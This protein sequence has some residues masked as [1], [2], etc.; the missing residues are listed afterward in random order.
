MS[1]QINYELTLVFQGPVITQ[2][3]GT[4]Q[5]G[6]DAAM[7]YN[8]GLPALGGSLIK[9]NIRHTLN[10]F[11]KLLPE[12]LS[13][14][15]KQWF[16]EETSDEKY[17]PQRTQVDFDFFWTLTTLY[18]K[19]RNQ[20]TRIAINQETGTVKEGALQIVEDCFP[21]GSEN[22]VFSGKISARFKDKNEQ[23]RFEKWVNKALEYIPAMGGFKGIG[24]GRL[25]PD[26]RLSPM[27]QK[28]M[29]SVITTETLPENITRIGLE[30]EIDRPFCL[31]R[32][33][34]P[35]S[36]QIISEDFIPGN[37]IKGLIA[38]LYNNDEEALEKQ[39]SFNDLIITHALAAE[40][41]QS[42]R[43][44]PIPLSIAIYDGENKEIVDMTKLQQSN[45]KICRENVPRFF[46]DW[47]N[48]DKKRIV[49]AMQQSV[50]EP[51]RIVVVR[52]AIT[53]KGISEE[54]KLFSLECIDPKQ[55][56]WCADIDLC[57]IPTEKQAAVFNNLQQKIKRGLTGIGK[58]KAQ[59]KLT[60]HLDKTYKP[61]VNP[62]TPGRQII[63]LTTAARIL[64]PDLSIPATNSAK[65][66]KAAYQ[67]YWQKILGNEVTLETYFAQQSITSTY[68]HQ[69][70]NGK[71]EKAYYPEWLSK[72]GSVFVLDINNEQSIEKLTR[73]INTGLPAHPEIEGAEANWKT[74]PY[75]PEHGYGEIQI[76]N[77]VLSNQHIEE[78]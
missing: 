40:K 49:D 55:H 37:V 23:K 61:K 68:Y 51:E 11:D 24:W 50:S 20:R 60:L 74:T 38:R 22:P 76:N 14:D 1:L 25:L 77:Q 4:I 57:N 78:A 16:G 64:P 5:L 21:V 46:P 70:R 56:V 33:R 59:A 66:L 18:E 62:L 43:T 73:L 12:M 47:K 39:L 34:T 71:T 28:K 10:E 45:N 72:A 8:Q 13:K 52:T 35:E 26:S 75:L 53:N 36:N 31:G 29:E 2:T 27:P 63:T 65:A 67:T 54:G 48:G 58:T 42:K 44:Q 69:Q 41:N 15:I 30:L 32:P 7:Q 6:L 3:S 9:G 17:T 19:T